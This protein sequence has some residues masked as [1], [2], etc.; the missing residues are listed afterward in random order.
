VAIKTQDDRTGRLPAD[1]E[2]HLPGHYTVPGTAA[3]L[4]EGWPP[5][6]PETLA[7]LAALIDVAPTDA[8]ANPQAA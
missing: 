7:A 1:A 6:T 5:P 2:D 8:A 3:E 4:V